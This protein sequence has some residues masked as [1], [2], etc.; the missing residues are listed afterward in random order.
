VNAV[1]R[2]F[3]IAVCEAINVEH[4]G[5]CGK[6]KVSGDNATHPMPL[7]DLRGWNVSSGTGAAIVKMLL[8]LARHV[9]QVHV[10]PHAL[11]TG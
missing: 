2:W 8:V 5:C 10:L 9:L 4:I 11:A 1:L 6:L 7:E 3:V